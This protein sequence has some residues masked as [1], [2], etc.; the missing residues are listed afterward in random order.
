MRFEVASNVLF[1]G[2]QQVEHESESVRNKHMLKLINGFIDAVDALG[3]RL[4][5][6]CGIEDQT[7]A[8]ALVDRA[9]CR[10]LVSQDS[11]ALNRWCET[12]LA[13]AHSHEHDHEQGFAPEFIPMLDTADDFLKEASGNLAD[14]H[15]AM[16]LHPPIADQ[17]IRDRNIN[18]GLAIMAQVMLV[19]RPVTLCSEAC[20]QRVIGDQA[21]PLALQEKLLYGAL[22]PLLT[23]IESLNTDRWISQMHPVLKDAATV[24]LDLAVF[25]VDLT[26]PEPDA[27]HRSEEIEQAR[28][29]IDASL[30]ESLAL[31]HLIGEWQACYSTTE[32]ENSLEQLRVSSKLRTGDFVSVLSPSGLHV[33]A[34]IQ[35]DGRATVSSQQGLSF[36]QIDGEFQLVD[37]ADSDLERDM[38]SATDTR[39]RPPT[40]RL[41][42]TIKQ[43]QTLLALD[44]EKQTSRY[45]TACKGLNNPD[46]VSPA[47]R[48]QA[49]KLQKQ[50]KKMRN[51]AS[52]LDGLKP[53]SNIVDE[54]Q[55]QLPDLAERLRD[56]ATNLVFKAQE[57]TSPETRWSLIKAYAR[58]QASQLAELLQAGQIS[59][60]RKPTRLLS[61][62][63]GLLFEVKI[64]P[65]PDAD[66]TSYPPVWLHLHARKSMSLNAVRKSDAQNFDAAHLKSDKEKNRGATWRAAERASGRYD[67]EIHRSPVGAQLLQDLI[68]YGKW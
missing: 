23:N 53:A 46:L 1:Q 51:V 8:N 13:C 4:Q 15:R 12:M 64:Q 55:A 44:I 25:T 45:L 37:D 47:Y 16:T 14:I 68:R 38:E 49:E 7:M 60:V 54:Q 59:Q 52:R 6:Q 35:E 41:T 61:T 32:I 29:R 48:L 63:P 17:I 10:F 56:Q 67:A 58:P 66:G 57:L 36:K 28:I 33:P 50:A 11:G 31:V 22:C 34:Q 26:L 62:P 30:R 21:A 24:C 40:S 27:N 20:L 2:H 5:S 9:H 19:L 42:K 18:V 3:P 39:T 43:A 65:K